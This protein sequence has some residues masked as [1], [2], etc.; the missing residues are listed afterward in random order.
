[1]IP[2]WRSSRTRSCRISKQVLA[3]LVDTVMV[4]WPI[5]PSPMM[6]R[7]PVKWGSSYE[8]L[9][10]EAIMRGPQCPMKSWRPVIQCRPGAKA[11][12]SDGFL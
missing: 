1:M 12:R 9:V 6:G 8:P 5:G 4:V 10:M 2:A 7:T 11:G 3:P